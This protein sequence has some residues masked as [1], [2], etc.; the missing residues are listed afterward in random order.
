MTKPIA[1]VNIATD[2][3]ATWIGITNQMADTFSKYAMTAN[4]DTNGGSTPGNATLTGIFS[5]NT[6][7]A[8]TQLR[9]GNVTSTANLTVT[10]NAI[11][12]GALVRVNSANAYINGTAFTSV[13]NVYFNAANVSFNATA[14]TLSG[15]EANV[16][17]NIIFN[18]TTTHVNTALT[19]QTEGVMTIVSNSNMGASGSPVELFS[20]SKTAY[21]SAKITSSAVSYTGNTQTQ[22]LIIACSNE[23]N[24]VTITAY[25]TVSAPAGVNVGVYSTSINATHVSVKFNQTAQNTAVKALVQYIK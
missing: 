8:S 14:F 18:N 12:T 24:D 11:F 16:T 1:N 6:L 10:S 7:T 22:E 19:L 20:F 4:T 5:A 17:S 9:G 13:S 25:G 23:A 21:R 3:F 2:S 15:G